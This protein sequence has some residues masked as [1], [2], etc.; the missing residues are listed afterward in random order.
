MKYIRCNES[1]QTYYFSRGTG[2][3]GRRREKHTLGS[4]L[5]EYDSPDSENRIR[6]KKQFDS[7][8]HKKNYLAVLKRKGSKNINIIKSN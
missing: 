6:T 8:I 2:S 7:P 3:E 4:Y 1:E 5:I